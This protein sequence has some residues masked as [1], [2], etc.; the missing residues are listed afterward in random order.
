[1]NIKKVLVTGASGYIGRHVVKELLNKGYYVIA[2]DFN[3]KGVDERAEFSDV[4]L[5]SGDKDIYEQFGCP[6]VLIHMAW[7]DGFIHNSDAHMADLSAHME[8]LKHMIDGGVKLVSVMGSMHEI[9]YHEGAIKAD[10]PCNPQSMYGIAKNALRQALLL[11][12]KDKDVIVDWLRAYY[13][14]GDDSRGSSIFAKIV[15]AV[16]D[17]K[18]TFPFTSGKNLYDFVHVDEL[19]RM[20]VAASTQEDIQGIINVCTGKP[21]SLAEQVEWYIKS[22]NYDISLL[23]GQFPDRP[24]DSP[25]VWGDASD[26]SVIMQNYR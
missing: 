5:F 1:M 8:F 9:G 25:G 24:Y 23:Y 3:Y 21:V 20:I 15:Q 6:D 14:F 22:H 16:E 17:G 11:Y 4:K 18:K 10:T 19:A 12:A 26:I 13:I 2:S 7:R